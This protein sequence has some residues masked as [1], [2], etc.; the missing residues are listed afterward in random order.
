M[1]DETEEKE[2]MAM[3]LLMHDFSTISKFKIIRS[4]LSISPDF[5]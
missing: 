5:K 1:R 3:R 2:T 4:N